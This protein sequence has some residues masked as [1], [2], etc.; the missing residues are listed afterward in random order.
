MAVTEVPGPFIKR[1]VD[2]GGSSAAPNFRAIEKKSEK[3]KTKKRYL[4][5]IINT[6]T[7]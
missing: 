3:P 2:G 5:K 4:P 6:I 1:A 7:E